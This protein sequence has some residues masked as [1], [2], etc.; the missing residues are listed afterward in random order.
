MK[1]WTVVELLSLSNT[2]DRNLSDYVSKWQNL[3]SMDFNCLLKVKGFEV[4]EDER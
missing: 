2:D 1:R 3:E 4:G